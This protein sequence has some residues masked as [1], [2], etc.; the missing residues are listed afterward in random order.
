MKAMDSCSGRG[1][2]RSEGCRLAWRTN[3]QILHFHRHFDETKYS[4]NPFQGLWLC[5]GGGLRAW[6][7][8]GL[9]M[10]LGSS[11]FAPK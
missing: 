7:D 5:F 1:T 4:S 11:V 6:F 10:F 9:R 2:N 8:A 3:A